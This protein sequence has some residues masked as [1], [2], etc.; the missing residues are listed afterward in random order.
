MDEVLP[1]FSFA[2]FHMPLQKRG[3]SPPTVFVLQ[4]GQIGLLRIL[5]QLAVC[6]V[7]GTVGQKAAMAVQRHDTYCRTVSY[8]CERNF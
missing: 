7:G 5:V 8:G 2:L 4:L 6:I 1:V 3:S